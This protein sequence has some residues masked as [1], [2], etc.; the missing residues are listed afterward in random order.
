MENYNAVK[1]VEENLK[2]IFAYS[3]SRVGNRTE[4]EDLTSDIILAIIQNGDKIKDPNAF[5][6]FVWGIA[7]NTY[8][9]FIRKKQKYSCVELDEKASTDDC[10][11]ENIC[12]SEDLNRLRRELTLLSREHRECTVSYYIDGLSCAETAEKLGISL[13]MVKYYLFKTRKIL[14]EGINMEREYGIKSYKPS[15]FYLE[16]I[17]S[18]SFN[19]EYKNL[20]NRK[21]PGNILLTSY[22]TPI[23]IRELSLELGVASPYLED[24]IR[25]LEKYDLV[26]KVGEE[27]YQ[28]NLVIFTEE[29]DDAFHSIAKNECVKRLKSIYENVKRK[30]TEIIN[31]G[32]IGN[33][34]EDNDLFWAL[35][36]FIMRKG[37]QYFENNNPAFSRDDKL[38]DGATGVNYGVDYDGGYAD[39]KYSCLSFA[40]YCGLEGDYGIAFADF[41]ILPANNR[42]GMDRASVSANINEALENNYN[43]VIPIFTNEQ[44]DILADMLDPEITE[45]GSLYNY[46]TQTAVNVMLQH[47]PKHVKSQVDH[48]IGS[49]VFFRTV[50]F[51]GACAVETGIINIPIHNRPV[52]LYA[53]NINK[54]VNTGDVC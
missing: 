37:N 33:T 11:L 53:Y 1:F 25:L 7:A 5:Y 36:W 48:I 34:L 4:A 8:K 38:Y 50:G 44:L 47:A 35:L 20:F 21:L 15:K 49:T 16:T 26:R 12:A 6:G 2:T 22:Y 17:F 52:A 9:S 45:M 39:D 28:T 46:L 18:G 3:F 42:F 32:F 29:F 31:I 54:Q 23:T 40:G 27:K 24:E 30:L 19:A 51:I 14:K 43:A 41:G 13:E 10:V